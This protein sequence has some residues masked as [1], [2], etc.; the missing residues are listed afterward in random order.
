[1][2]WRS[3]P[4]FAQ[5]SADESSSDAARRTARP[6]RRAPARPP[7]WFWRSARLS[8]RTISG[9]ALRIPR[10]WRTTR[11]CPDGRR[12]EPIQI[13]PR[14]ATVCAN[15]STGLILD[16]ASRSALAT[17]AAMERSGSSLPRR[18][19]LRPAG[20]FGPVPASGRE[21]RPDVTNHNP[22][23][24][25]PLV[26]GDRRGTRNWRNEEEDVDVEW[27]G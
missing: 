24:A 18:F 2:S 4:S 5:R 22:A 12:R 23:A 19:C 27:E 26:R 1:M 25:A 20:S 21:N 3:H 6:R 7:P 13:V 16:L 9:P 8:S 14:R 10:V 15:V 17:A 11:D